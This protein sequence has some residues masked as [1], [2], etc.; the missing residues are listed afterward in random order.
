MANETAPIEHQE[1]E[2]VTSVEETN[3]PRGIAPRRVTA[4]D[5]HCPTCGAEKDH[6][7]RRLTPGNYK[8]IDG[9]HKA[10]RMEADRLDV[11]GWVVV[12]LDRGSRLRRSEEATDG[13]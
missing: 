11:G 3:A 13:S 6:L 10:R 1:A 5:V 7:C 8:H 4:R 12:T 9:V 2:G